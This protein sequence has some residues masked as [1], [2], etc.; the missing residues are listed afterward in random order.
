MKLKL[1]IVAIFLLANNLYGQKINKGKSNIDILKI[2]T[3]EV[4]GKNM[5]YYVEFK[6]NGAKEVD[7]IKCKASFYDNFGILKGKRNGLWQSGNFISVLK[8]GET[9]KDLQSNFIDGATNIYIV[10]TEVHH[11][12]DQ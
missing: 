2:Y 12:S 5:G 8:P 10:I 7:G 9:T 4:L 11:K 3:Q 1:S 6:N